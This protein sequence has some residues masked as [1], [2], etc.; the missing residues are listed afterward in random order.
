MRGFV[1]GPSFVMEIETSCLDWQPYLEEK[2]AS[3]FTLIVVFMLFYGR[4]CYASFPRG[5]FWLAFD[6]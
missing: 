1:S 4:L 2:R 3:C 5:A 6:L